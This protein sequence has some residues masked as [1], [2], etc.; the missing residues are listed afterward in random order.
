MIS[1]NIIRIIQPVSNPT[2]NSRLNA[3]HAIL[4]Y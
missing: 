1:P 2:K 3:N 4:L